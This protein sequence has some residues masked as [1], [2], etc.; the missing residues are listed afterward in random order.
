M[1]KNSLVT[2]ITC[3]LI[4]TLVAQDLEKIRE[5]ESKVEEVVLESAELGQK[6]QVLVYTPAHY[7][8]SKFSYYNV[9]YVFD[10]Q[11][12]ALFDTANGITNLLTEGSQDF[13][14]V[15]IKATWIE[16][17]MYAR[18]HDLLPSDTKRN[19]G[20]KSGG[21]AE[22]FLAYVKNEVVPYVESNYRILPQRTAV[23]HSLS[24]SFLIYSLLNEPELFDNYIAISPNLEDDDQ[25]LVRGLE[26]FDTGQ[27]NTT[28]FLY[29]SHAN[30]HKYWPDWKPANEKAYR[31]VR[32][33]LASENFR[34]VI[35][36]YPMEGH[37][38]GFIPGITS[39][40]RIYL[41]S[42]QPLQEMELSRDEYEVT[43]RIKVLEEDDEVYIT[44]NQESLGNWQ[45][46][47]VKMQKTAP[48]ERM[49]TL[50]VQDPVQV[51]FTQGEWDS[52]AWIKVGQGGWSTRKL[53]VRPEDGAEYLFEV[54]AYKN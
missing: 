10:A 15:G 51:Q 13:I 4:G 25:R 40:M 48:L 44:G 7:Q 49:V 1:K 23:G 9:I 19:M 12:R 52:Q 28:K 29:L 6:R 30:E 42:I 21:N 50:K 5:N 22:A 46:N 14:V 31:I 36:E 27:F 26:K 3:F 53:V 34:A 38:S 18:N 11:D 2:L 17:E 37:R 35:E 47:Q 24:A 54:H 39:A 43:F 33:S 20:P 41:D 16:E 8:E 45:P 32:E